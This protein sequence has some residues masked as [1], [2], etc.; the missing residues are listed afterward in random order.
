MRILT[1]TASPALAKVGVASTETMLT[2]SSRTCTAAVAVRL[3]EGEAESV[4]VRVKSNGANGPLPAVSVTVTVG[5]GKLEVN[6][7]G[8]RSTVWRFRLPVTPGGRPPIV[9]PKTRFVDAVLRRKT[10]KSLLDC[11]SRTAEV[12]FRAR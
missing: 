2:I 10:V 5:P 3:F 7:F 9:K 4:A 6:S 11:A 12:G 8:A 1:S